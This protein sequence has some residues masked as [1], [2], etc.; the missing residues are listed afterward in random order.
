MAQIIP[1]FILVGG[2]VLA[3]LVFAA[4]IVGAGQVTARRGHGYLHWI[5]YALLL[6]AAL[7]NLISGRDITTM[8]MNFTEQ[9]DAVRPPLMAMLQPVVSLLILAIASER[10]VNRWLQ[11]QRD[12]HIPVLPLSSYL[13]FWLGTV[14]APA[15]FGARPN[16]SH[17][18]LYPLVMG[19]AVL[20]A[21]GVERDLAFRAARD[22]VFVFMAASLLLIPVAPRMVLDLGYTQGLLPGIPRLAG[23]A[24]HPVT[25]GV[26]A[27]LGLLCFMASPYRRRWLNRLAWITGLAVLFMAQSKTAWASF[28]LCSS[29][30]VLTRSAPGFLRRAGD[31]ERNECGITVLLAF[32]LVVVLATGLAVY[33]DIGST[34]S[35]F[36]NSSE[37]AQLTSLTGRDKIWAIAYDEWLRNP[38]FGY[39]PTIWDSEYRLLIGMP[40]ATHAHNQFMDT[41]SRSGAVGAAALV[42]YALVL[43]GL[44][45]RYARASGGLSLALFLALALQ[46]V[47]E[48]PLLLFGYGLEFV[49]H[50][51]LL[52]TLTTA[53]SASRASHNAA[54]STARDP[55]FTYARVPLG[56]TRVGP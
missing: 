43:L 33:A 28:I 20:L 30:M 4:G 22:A 53:A 39:G 8:A 27:Q 42:F 38:V 56:T 9:G 6:M 41:L 29:C 13:V 34:L 32:V 36:F 5:F 15:L 18:Y 24:T 50:L 2:S 52:M 7:P 40:N 45:M 3:V 54:A 37:G 21:S 26:L 12:A 47:S 48:V 17:D 44:S 11:P 51:L 16:I 10:I 23:L 46:S 1:L 31:P 35:G 49:T 14:A 55:K 19:V 25:L